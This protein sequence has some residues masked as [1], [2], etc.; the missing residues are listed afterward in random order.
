M[1]LTSMSLNDLDLNVTDLEEGITD[2]KFK[3]VS[4][5]RITNKKIIDLFKRKYI[6]EFNQKH[7]IWEP[8]P[9]IMASF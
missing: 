7:L 3:L 6:K 2:Q 9:T 8:G 4:D 1:T 5:I